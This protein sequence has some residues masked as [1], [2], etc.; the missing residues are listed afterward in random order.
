MVVCLPGGFF[1][2][3]ELL[4]TRRNFSTEYNEVGM[5]RPNPVNG[6]HDSKKIISAIEPSVGGKKSEASDFHIAKVG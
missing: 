1:N 3:G 5:G 4:V 6:S 2:V